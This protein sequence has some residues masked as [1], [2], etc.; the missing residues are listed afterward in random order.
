MAVCTRVLLPVL[1]MLWLQQQIA[2][3]LVVAAVVGVAVEAVAVMLVVAAVVGVAVEA[4][5][6]VYLY[7]VAML[8]VAAVATHY[9]HQHYYLLQATTVA[10]VHLHLALLSVRPVSTTNVRPQQ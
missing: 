10:D 3:M 9:Y 6:L 7:D 2:V 5:A 8:L 4:V 1:L